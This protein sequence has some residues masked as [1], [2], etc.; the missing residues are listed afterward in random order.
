M[1]D[2]T[3]EAKLLRAETEIKRLGTDGTALQDVDRIAADALDYA[4]EHG[5]QIPVNRRDN[6]AYTVAKAYLVRSREKIREMQRDKDK[7]RRHAEEVF[8][9]MDRVEYFDAKCDSGFTRQRENR[10]ARSYVYKQAVDYALDVI[11]VM[12]DNGKKDVARGY[13][14]LT[15]QYLKMSGIGAKK[16]K[17]DKVQAALNGDI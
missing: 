4:G 1:L 14:T 15:M 12:I 16:K 9:M 11:G 10:E 3:L 13:F 8:E 2:P 6:I 17:L 7:Q 5:L